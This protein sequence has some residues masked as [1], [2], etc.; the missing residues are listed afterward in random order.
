MA[1]HVRVRTSTGRKIFV[2]F[3]NAFLLI[4]GFLCLLPLIHVFMVSLSSG[5]AA[6]A[7]K[8]VLWPVEFTTQAYEFVI[9][10]PQ[11]LRSA[12]ISIQRT[13][14]GAPLSVFL[15]L[16][17]AYPLSKRNS[18][19]RWRTFYV[20]VFFFT[21]LFHGGLIP[22]YFVVR[23]TGLMDTLGA[24]ILPQ[25]VAVFNVILMLNFFRRQPIELEEAAY[26]DGA[27]HW[28]ILVR[29]Y[30]PLAKAAIATILLFQLVRHWNEW[31]AGMIYMSRPSRYP[32]Q[33]YIRTLVTPDAQGLDL[34]RI[35][36]II[37]YDK[38]S[39]ETS[40]AAQIFVAVVPIIMVYPFL[41][42]H[43]TK[44]ITLGSLKG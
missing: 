18:K 22:T 28:T 31:F 24:L 34:N 23:E 9:V 30:I 15:S 20:W 43:F 33:T 21:M 16:L 7:G 27:S 37:A 11:F 29:I 10:R 40:K 12:W 1:K 26:M 36:D 39:S 32:L 41:Q 38:I 5:A 44:G 25:A 8:V 17:T 6:A 42:K 35:D 19:F 14:I 13:L 3:N 4:L 2:V